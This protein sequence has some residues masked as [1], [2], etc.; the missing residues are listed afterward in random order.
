MPTS[1]VRGPRPSS[2]AAGTRTGD[3]NWEALGFPSRSLSWGS[4]EGAGAHNGC[5]GPGASRG[6]MENHQGAESCFL[7][8]ACCRRGRGSPLGHPNPANAV[9]LSCFTA[10]KGK[11]KD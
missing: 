1:Q 7:C 11:E 10:K 4:E 9:F 3:G 2:R 5:P 8:C 6:L